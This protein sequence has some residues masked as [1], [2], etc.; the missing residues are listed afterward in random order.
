MQPPAQ[1]AAAAAGEGDAFWDR[2]VHVTEETLPASQ[3]LVPN[4]SLISE[5]SAGAAVSYETDKNSCIYQ[6]AK[7]WLGLPVTRAVI[8]WLAVSGRSTERQGCQRTA[9]CVAVVAA[10]TAYARHTARDYCKQS[11]PHKRR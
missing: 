9:L 3:Q 4:S 2:A 11:Q 10:A 7:C 1:A 5:P 8:T 6:V